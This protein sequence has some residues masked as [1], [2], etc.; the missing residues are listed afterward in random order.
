MANLAQVA[1]TRLKRDHKN[2]RMTEVPR[3]TRSS[4]TTRP[5]PA[6]SRWLRPVPRRPPLESL[7][8]GADHFGSP[9][10][11][12]PASR[13]S[14]DTPRASCWRT[15]PASTRRTPGGSGRVARADVHSQLRT[16]GSSSAS[17]APCPRL[18]LSPRRSSQAAAVAA[19]RKR[20]RQRYNRS[21]SNPWEVISNGFR[22]PSPIAQGDATPPRR[23]GQRTD[24]AGW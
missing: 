24:G 14:S 7:V 20:R 15:P 6:R 8:R 21:A 18:V 19:D 10:S 9:P 2:A 4:P 11:G 3:F 5:G 23:R 22:D 13:R 17:R 16:I 1:L 12:L